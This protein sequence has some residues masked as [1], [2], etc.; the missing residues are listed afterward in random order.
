MSNR[1]SD[2]RGE[3]A[4]GLFLDRYFYPGLGQQEL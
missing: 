3:K 2:T 1:K 4:S